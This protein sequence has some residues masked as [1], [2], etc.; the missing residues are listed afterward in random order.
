MSYEYLQPRSAN[1]PYVLPSLE[2]FYIDAN[3][4]DEEDISEGWYW[5]ACFPE[6]LPDSEAFGPFGTYNAALKDARD[7]MN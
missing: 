3:R 1:N 4:A 7:S 5:W 2:V 6:C